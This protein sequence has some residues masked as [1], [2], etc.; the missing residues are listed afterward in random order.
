[1]YPPFHFILLSFTFIRP[2]PAF[3]SPLRFFSFLTSERCQTRPSFCDC[4][5]RPS[6]ISYRYLKSLL[7]LSSPIRTQIPAPFTHFPF[8]LL[9]HLYPSSS[10]LPSSRSRPSSSSFVLRSHTF[11]T[12][13]HFPI[14]SPHPPWILF[15]VAACLWALKELSS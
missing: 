4:S 6:L 15:F 10:A 13:S 5:I 14:A 9:F 7:H 8:L 12:R 2:L 3:L 1:M 11:S